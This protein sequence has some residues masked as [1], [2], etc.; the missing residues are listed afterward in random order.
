M[1][2]GGMNPKQM[3]KMMK[4]MG[5]KMDEIDAEEV[6]IRCVDKE[7]RITSPQVVKT[8]V[9][10]Q[11][12]FQISG[13]VSE[14]EGDVSIEIEDDDVTMVAEQAGVSEEKARAALENAGG[15]LA[16]AIMELKK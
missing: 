13:D 7:I 10:G 12:M 14:E 11:E 6:V 15:D 5:V 9:S 3:K 2:P 1:M 8:I 16:E 4:R